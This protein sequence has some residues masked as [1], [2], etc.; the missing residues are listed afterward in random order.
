MA[1]RLKVFAWSD[2][3]H[4]FTVAATSRP[5]ALEAWGVAQDLFK[6]GLAAEVTDGPDH[7]AALAAPGTVIRTGV[8]VDPGEVRPVKPK[9]T[10]RADKRAKARKAKLRAELETLEAETEHTLAELIAER[11]AIEK[12]IA[13]VEAKAART[14][15]RLK[16]ALKRDDGG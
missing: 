11:D 4:R 3:F 13:A 8:A 5:K 10:D 12:H 7:K 9:Q 15:A 6:S 1:A 16:T 2:G 14:R